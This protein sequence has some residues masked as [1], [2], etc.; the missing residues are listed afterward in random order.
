MERNQH[1]V[2]RVGGFTA[3]EVL[4]VVALMAMLA[5]FAAPSVSRYRQRAQARSHAERVMGV[6]H[7][8]RAQA[9]S[10]GQPVLVLFDDPTE[11]AL[12]DWPEGVFARVIRGTDGNYTVDDGVDVVTDMEVEAGQGDSVSA[13]GLGPSGETPFSSAVLPDEWGGGTLSALERGTS[14]QPYPPDDPDSPVRGVWFSPQG[15]ALQVNA[16][17]SPAVTGEGAF[18]VTDN[19]TAV[20]AVV[21]RALGNVGIRTLNP[22]TLEWN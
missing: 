7:N 17:P 9:I 1:R 5:A 16:T 19:Y 8:A 15:M 11:P 14:F 21:L 20:Y 10:F 22:E 4:I 12:P 3:I 6:L 2:R 13:Y 18:Y